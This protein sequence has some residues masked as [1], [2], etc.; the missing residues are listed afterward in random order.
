MVDISPPRPMTPIID[1]H[2]HSSIPVYHKLIR[3]MDGWG[4]DQRFPHQTFFPPKL[5]DWSAGH[6]LDIMSEESIRAQVLSLPDATVGLRGETACRCAREINEALA[7]IVAQHPRQFAAFAV[8]PHDDTESSLREIEYAL[9][10][11]KLDGICT[12]TNIRGTYLGD[13]L[14]D[15]WLDELHR[16]S[17]VLFVHPTASGI[18]EPSAPLFIEFCFD[19]SKMVMNMVLSG[20]KRRFAGIKLISTHGGGTIP[21]ISHRLEMIEPIVGRSRLS[22]EDI[23]TDLRSFHYDLTSCMATVPLS[24]ITRFI[25]PSKL[26]M[27]F[28]FPYAPAKLIR[29]EV[30]RFLAFEGISDVEKDMI[31]CGNALE[32]FPRLV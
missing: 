16:R 8:I 3:D 29:P 5:P 20:A 1:V 19:S 21:Y 7:E 11:L 32:L 18:A 12:T 31:L 10:V 2:S 26:L 27:G 17:A 14:F 6:A 25:E 28:D 22:E 9:D 24:A 30:E 23:A 13:P 4:S 15:P